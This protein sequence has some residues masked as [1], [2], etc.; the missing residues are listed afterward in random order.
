[1]SRSNLW[2]E[3]YVS[4]R[5]NL[6]ERVGDRELLSI[7][8][9]VVEYREY[10]RFERKIRTFAFVAMY[11]PIYP[12]KPDSMAPAINAMTTYPCDPSSLMSAMLNMTDKAMHIRTTNTESQRYSW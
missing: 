11:I 3:S 7:Y 5:N 9:Y 10:G 4:L 2:F 1:M 8:K 6:N 12:A